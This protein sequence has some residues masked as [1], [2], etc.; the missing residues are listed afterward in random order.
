MDDSYQGCRRL[1]RGLIRRRQRR[2]GTEGGKASDMQY[3]MST[4]TKETID[5]TDDSA[6]T[7][8]TEKQHA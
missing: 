4:S 5:R 8:A 3:T 7:P 6:R 2:G 1:D